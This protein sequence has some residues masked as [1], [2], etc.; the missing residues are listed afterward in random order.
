MMMMKTDDDDD[1]SDCC[2]YCNIGTQSSL[3]F[4]F[5]KT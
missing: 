1:D 4:Y 2:K 3:G 5:C